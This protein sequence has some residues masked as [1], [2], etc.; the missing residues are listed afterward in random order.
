MPATTD[1][2][3]IFQR[4]M[5]EYRRTGAIAGFSGGDGADESSDDTDDSGPDDQSADTSQDTD[6]LGEKGKEAIR[7][8]R[9]ARKAAEKERSDLK[10]R[11]DELEAKQREAAEA[12]AKEEGRYK[13]LLEER[14]RELR[15]KEAQLADRDRQ[16]WRLKAATKHG[17][18]DD[19][20]DRIT[21]DSEEAMDADAK[22]LATFLKAKDAP[23]TDNG[24]RP[25]RT[26][27]ADP[28]RYQ[29]FAKWG[30]RHG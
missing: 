6:Q 25:P 9:E 28:K 30:L 18:P 19:L 26:P 16:T 23:D 7:R 5:D 21:G 15:E 4:A 2:R 29:D 11:L 14:E 27:K 10:K 20:V 13:E 8:E 17:I 22:T 24:P 12:K 1:P 3:S